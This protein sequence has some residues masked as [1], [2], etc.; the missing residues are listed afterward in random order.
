L[1][2]SEVRHLLLIGA[3][4]DNEVTAA[5]PLT[6]TLE[7]IRT[8][9]SPVQ[10]VRLAPLAGEDVRQL[11]ADAVRCEVARAAALAGLVHGKT[12]GNPFFVVQFLSERAHEGLLPFDHQ[13]A[14]W[15]WDLEGIQAKKYT[16]NVVDLM[17]GKL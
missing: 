4:R 9:G 15:S 2:R 16:A 12:G 13:S 3:Y 1:T 17:V 8:A 14:R 5:H 7:A 10:E 6:H 11:V